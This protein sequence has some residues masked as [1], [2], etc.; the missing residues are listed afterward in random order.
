VCRTGSPDETSAA[1]VE[2]LS[3]G[4]SPRSIWDAMLCGAGELLM[5]RRGIVALHAVTMTNAMHHC[6]QATASDETRK[7]LLLQN[8]AFLPMFRAGMGKDLA[9]VRIDRLDAE[10]DVEATDAVADIFS[11]LEG[12]RLSSARRTLGYLRAGRSVGPLMDAARR[13][14]FLKGTDSHDYKFSAAA[15]EDYHN[16]SPAWRDRFL[17]GSMFYFRGAAAKDNALVGRA[18]A[19]LDG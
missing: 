4:A 8:A 7:R 18:R 2:M 12:D 16:L 6:F 1:V 10:A 17:A 11:G 13:L 15:L 5:R 19:A 14:I 3:A 9:E